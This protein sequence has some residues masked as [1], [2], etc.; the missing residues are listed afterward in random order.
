MAQ[1]GFDELRSRVDQDWQRVVDVLSRKIALG[2]VS[3]LGITAD[4]MK[5][6]AEF[7]AEV[8]REEGVD[9]RVVQSRNPDGTTGAWE[10]V[11]AR[12]V[13]PQ[14]PTVLLYAHHDVQPVPDPKEW[15]TDPFVATAKDDGRLY[16]RGAA[17]DGGGIAIHSGALKA[18]GD[19]LKV[20]IKVFIE[21]R[22]RWAPRASSRSSAPIRTS[23]T[24]M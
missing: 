16:G 23:S 22:R 21:G 8:L 24:P 5:H 18:L 11:G 15:D 2:C 19:D 6:S 3:A 13:D 17:D 7:V 14:A 4:H 20:N 9:A 12:I 10:V 1:V